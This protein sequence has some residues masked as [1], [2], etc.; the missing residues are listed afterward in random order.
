M[1]LPLLNSSLLIWEEK[2]RRYAPNSS[3]IDTRGESLKKCQERFQYAVFEFCVIIITF[4]Y[5]LLEYRCRITYIVMHVMENIVVTAQTGLFWQHDIVVAVAQDMLQ[6]RYLY[7]RSTCR[8]VGT[9]GGGNGGSQYPTVYPFMFS[10]FQQY[11]YWQVWQQKRSET[12]TELIPA[13][14]YSRDIASELIS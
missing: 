3:C 12:G 13:S 14:R 1:V 9:G 7:C 6:R 4:D 2:C 11:D 8:D 5:I 10:D